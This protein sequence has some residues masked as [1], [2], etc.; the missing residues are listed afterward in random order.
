M[1]TQLGLTFILFLLNKSV[2]RGFF[3]HFKFALFFGTLM[4]VLQH[5]ISGSLFLL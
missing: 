2:K 1:H 5:V 3:Y 4:L